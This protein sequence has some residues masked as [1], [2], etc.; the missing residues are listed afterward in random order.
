MVAFFPYTYQDIVLRPIQKEDLEFYQALFKNEVAMKKYSG[1]VRDIT[2]R[3]HGWQ[4]RWALHGYSAIAICDLAEKVIG[5][6]VLGHG[7]YDADLKGWS[8]VAIVI[9]L[10]HWGERKGIQT[11][12]A[13]VQYA[14]WLFQNG[15]GAPCD[16]A[17]E[18]I[19]EVEK[20]IEN[21]PECKVHRDKEGKIKWIYLPLTE[22]RATSSSENHAAQKIFQR[23]FVL[24]NGGQKIER[25]GE[26]DRSGREGERG[27]STNPSRERETRE[28]VGQ[29]RR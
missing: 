10:D 2:N 24:E 6:V 19:P 26:R 3:F 16:V 7:D 17:E 1:G 23:I 8:E 29:L 13:I 27:G 14:K 25:D 22:I 21:H 28:S 5:H 15:H 4:E 9:H 12:L 20:L 18:Q 11:I